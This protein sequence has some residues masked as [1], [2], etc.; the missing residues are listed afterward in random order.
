AEAHSN[1]GVLLARLDKPA[2]ATAAYRRAVEAYHADLVALRL[3]KEMEGHESVWHLAANPDIRKGTESTKV[4]LEQNTMAT[5]NVLEAARR[6]DVKNVVFS[7]TSTIYGRA[8]VLP[9]PEDY[10]PCLPIS[11]YGASKL[12]CEG[13]ISAY[14]EL[15]GMNGWIYRFANI[16]GRRST[17]GILYDLVE[18]LN[19]NPNELEVLGDGNQR[20]SYL[21]VDECVDAMMFGFKNAKDRLN[22]FNLGADD[23]ITVRRI[24]EVL[25]EETELKDVELKYTG[26]ESGWAGD[27]PIF[28]LATKKMADLGW[29]PKHN[30]EEAI[31]EAAKIVVREHLKVKS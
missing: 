22:Y 19:R 16:I 10:G 11:L 12:A 25:V 15:Y 8:K 21:L 28:L 14:A 13:L 26:G 1:R 6:T 18:K 30:S 17:H 3:M 9:T 24:V 31:R 29:K 20:K 7:S 27:V 2:E 23:Q 5:Y 4:D